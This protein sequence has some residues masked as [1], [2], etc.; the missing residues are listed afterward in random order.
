MSTSKQTVSQVSFSKATVSAVKSA[1]GKAAKIELSALAV[2]NAAGQRMV[3][4]LLMMCD[5]PDR[6]D[7]FKR[8]KARAACLEVFKACEG[9]SDSAVDNYPT[10]VKIAFIH[11]VDFSASLF[12]RDGQKA[13]GLD[14]VKPADKADKAGAVKTTTK[15]EAVKTARKL[16]VQLRLL[17]RDDTAAGVVDCMRESFPDFDETEA[18]AKL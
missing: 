1:F 18:E 16:I 11:G 15:A 10:S 5:S 8:S 4:E 9:L 6:E 7:F 17:G 3:D 13:A 14:L 2:R 12:T